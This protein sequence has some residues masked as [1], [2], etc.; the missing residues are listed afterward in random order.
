MSGCRRRQ[1]LCGQAARQSRGSGDGSD[2][3]TEQGRQSGRWRQI[4]DNGSPPFCGNPTSGRNRHRNRGQV[5]VLPRLPAQ[6][7]HP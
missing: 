1:K 4:L 2:A 7:F 3:I 6:T 5:D